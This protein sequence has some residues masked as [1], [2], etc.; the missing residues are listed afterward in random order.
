MKFIYSQLLVFVLLFSCSGDDNSSEVPNNTTS[1]FPYAINN[2]WVYDVS[3]ESFPT[4]TRDSLY[5]ANQQTVNGLSYYNFGANSNST[6][7]STRLYSENLHRKDGDDHLIFNESFDLSDL[8]NNVIDISINLDDAIMLS[9]TAPVG[10]ILGTIPNQVTSEA[11]GVSYT[12]D[13]IFKNKLN[14]TFDAIQV[15]SETFNTIRETQ[16]TINATI[17]VSISGFAIEV[18]SSQDVMTVYNRYAEN[19]G[20]VQ[21]IATIDYEIENI[22]PGISLP[23]PSSNTDTITQNIIHYNVTN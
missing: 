6:G 2:Y 22:P 20:L 1:F 3:S 17:T 18:L 19:V 4:V 13:Y 5:I 8:F 9:D 16:I 15:G 7:I 23:F 12:V 11:S 21:S 10:S 14:D